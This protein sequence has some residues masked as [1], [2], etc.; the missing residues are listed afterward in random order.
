MDLIVII[1]LIAKQLGLTD[2]Q[3][4]VT[5]LFVILF[6]NLASRLIPDDSKGAL[7]LVHKVA[8]ILGL[9]AANR[10]SRGVT[11]TTAVAALLP[12]EFFAPEQS[13]SHKVPVTVEVPGFARAA[14]GQFIKSPVRDDSVGG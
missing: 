10:I 5:L 13:T 1:D 7:G 6:S 2:A 14:N 11:T 3:L 4:G 12:E 9:Y 8:K